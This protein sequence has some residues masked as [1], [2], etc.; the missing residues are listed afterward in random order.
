MVDRILFTKAVIYRVLS[1]IFTFII[2]YA[3]TKELPIATSVTII[4]ALFSTVWYYLYDKIWNWLGYISID[5]DRVGI[6]YNYPNVP[7]PE[8][9]KAF[10]ALSR[11]LTVI[12]A[13]IVGFFFTYLAIFYYKTSAPAYL[14]FMVGTCLAILH[15]ASQALNQ[16]IKE[17]IEIDKINKPYR[18]IVKGLITPEEGKIYA[19]CAYVAS[20]LLGFVIGFYFFLWLLVIA[21]F[22]IFYTLP[23]LRV[24]RFFL[25]NNLWQGI[26]RGLLPAVAIFSIFNPTP[27]IFAIA[28]GTVIT[29]WLTGCQSSKD[30]ADIEGDK[31]FGIKT[32]FTVLDIE[33]AKIVIASFIILSFTLLN[34]FIFVLNTIP[35]S[36]SL[37]NILLIPSFGVVKLLEKPSKVTENNLAWPLMYATLA[38]W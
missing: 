18:P 13:F 14:P 4:L 15:V 25:V 29:I 1:A 31:K 5:L 38:L 24:K 22:S 35:L 6:R 17:E 9:F 36:M 33:K 27:D 23:P 19:T 32:L 10:V 21:F 11:P 7:L 26:A 37:L 16:S 20:L 28:I 3:L 2:V 34:I 30:I 8:K 12:G